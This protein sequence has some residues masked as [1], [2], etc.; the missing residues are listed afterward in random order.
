MTGAAA[1][2]LAPLMSSAR[3]GR[4]TDGWCTPP[5]VLERVRRVGPIALDPCTDASNPTGALKYITHDSY[6]GGLA[7]EW[8]RAR[9][10]QSA[11]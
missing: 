11:I 1:R 9:L 4:G 6:G 10:L 2:N 3:T 5:E 8:G 7:R